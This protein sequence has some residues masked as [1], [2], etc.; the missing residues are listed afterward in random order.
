MY[1]KLSATIDVIYH[2]ATYMNHLATYREM[3]N[4]TV[5]G[6]KRILSFACTGKQK[7]IHYISTL[8]VFNGGKSRQINEMTPIE[9]EVHYNSAGY[10]SSKWV[11]DKLMILAWERGV[12]SNIYRLGLV[13]GD[14]QKGRYDKAQSFYRF[15]QTYLELGCFGHDNLGN[16]TTFTPVDFISNAIVHLAYR[17]DINHIYH[18]TNH[19]IIDYIDLIKYYNAGAAKPLDIISTF[20]FLKKIK[21]AMNSGK[22]PPIVP[23]IRELLDLSEAE[24]QS[25]D[26]NSSETD[27]YSFLNVDPTRT[28]GILKEGGIN[29]P[30][31]NEILI[32][33]YFDYIAKNIPSLA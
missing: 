18:L 6:V 26:W 19:Q 1:R 33:R 8:S 27:L 7:M 15:L 23:I 24:L 13:T 29:M 14:S 20:E 5:E 10:A 28:L 16:K 9:H 12:P 3:K 22:T 25:I 11:A 30:E 32:K 17:P 21:E 4:T 2:C 31:I